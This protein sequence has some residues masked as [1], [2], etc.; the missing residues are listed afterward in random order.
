MT[1]RSGGSPDWYAWP[2]TWWDFWPLGIVLLAL[3]G[4]LLILELWRR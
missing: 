3:A 2:S 1:I 4:A